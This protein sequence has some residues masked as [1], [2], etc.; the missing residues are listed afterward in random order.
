MT[1]KR[2]ALSVASLRDCRHELKPQLLREKIRDTCRC[3]SIE[4]SEGR[5]FLKV[6][7]EFVRSMQRYLVIV[8]N[9]LRAIRNKKRGRTLLVS[10]TRRANAFQAAV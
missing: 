1:I 8:V 2:S 9:R 7:R 3:I 10:F 5:G 4:D 6:I